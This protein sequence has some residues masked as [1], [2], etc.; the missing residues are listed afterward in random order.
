MASLERLHEKFPLP[1]ES[2][3]DQDT[4]VHRTLYSTFRRWSSIYEDF[5]R[6][7]TPGGIEYCFQRIPTFRVHYPGATATKA[8][9][10]DS[11]YNHQHGVIN[12]WI[13]LTEAYGTNS[14][15]LENPLEEN[16]ARPVHLRPGQM[17]RFDATSIRHGSL[18]NDSGQT[19]VSFDFRII[20][21]KHFKPAGLRTVTSNVELRIGE[22]YAILD[23]RGKITY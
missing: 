14:I 9:H 5:V 21:R 7:I 15:W 22:Y 11:E 10:R 13:P 17:L 3:G 2:S 23:E 6:T 20:E 19:R 4:A 16:T 1:P 8:F 18:R 12:Y